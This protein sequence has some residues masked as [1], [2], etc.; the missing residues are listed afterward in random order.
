VWGGGQEGG[1][2]GVK[3]ITFGQYRLC[4]WV[5]DNTVESHQVGVVLGPEGS[6]GEKEACLC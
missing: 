2:H 3:S 4:D 5:G 6:K 1:Q